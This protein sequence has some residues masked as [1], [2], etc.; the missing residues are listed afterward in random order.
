MVIPIAVFLN[1]YELMDT[2]FGKVRSVITLRCCGS[3]FGLDISGETWHQ[4]VKGGTVNGPIKP[5]RPVSFSTK[6]SIC[7]GYSSTLGWLPVPTDPV[8]GPI[9]PIGK[10]YVK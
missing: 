7:T 10:P 3:A 8:T 6:A 1:M 5:P 2:S 9:Y 4:G